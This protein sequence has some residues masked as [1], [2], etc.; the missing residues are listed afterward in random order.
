MKN[1]LQF[2]HCNRLFS[3]A[4][5]A[6]A[7]I[8]RRIDLDKQHAL[9]A[10]PIILKYGDAENP[11][12]LIGIGSVGDGESYGVSKNKIFYIDAAELAESIEELTVVADS[13]DTVN[14][15]S[16][17]IEGKNHLS[18]DVKVPATRIIG[19]VVKN[20]SIMATEDGIFSLVDISYDEQTNSIV[21]NVNE[22]TK[23]INLPSHLVRGE[24]K[25][26]GEDAEKLVLYMS[27]GSAIKIDMVDLIEE[28]KVDE[29]PNSPIVLTKEHV[30]ATTSTHDVQWQDI[31]SADVRIA[32]ADAVA[33]NILQKDSTNRYLY[34]KGTASNIS[35]W[36][37]QEKM[38]LQDA[39]NEMI[40]DVSGVQGNIIT[41]LSDGIFANV[42]L[43]FDPARNVLTFAKSGNDPKE[44]RL[45]GVNFIKRGYY[46]AQNEN[47]VI[48]YIDNNGEQQEI[49]IPASGLITEWGVDNSTSTV[50]LTKTPHQVSG[51][52]VLTANVKIGGG[53]NTNNIL[54]V[55]TDGH[56]LYVDGVANNIK[57]EHDSNTTVKD[58][59]DSL[60]GRIDDE[61]ARATS[62]ETR[63]ENAIGAVVNDV[64]DVAEKLYGLSGTV[65]T[66]AEEVAGLNFSVDNTDTVSMTKENGVVTSEVNID[67]R[68]PNI[69]VASQDGIRADIDFSYDENTNT[70]TVTKTNS[71]E[72]QEIKLN[73]TSTIESITYNKLTETLDFTYYKY[74]DGVK[75][76]VTD[77]IDLSDLIEEWD[78]DNT[79]KNVTLVKVR[80][81]EHP[82]VQDKLSANV[83]ISAAENN[84][85]EEVYESDVKKLFVK[86]LEPTVNEVS[87]AVSAMEGDIQTINSEIEALSGAVSGCSLV[88]HDTESVKFERNGNDVN[89][90][91]LLRDDEN[92]IIS[93]SNSGLFAKVSLTYEASENKLFFQTTNMTEPVAI[94]L[95]GVET[96]TNVSYDGDDPQNKVIK[97]TFGLQ[98]GSE[99]T[100]EIPVND[101]AKP[102]DV[103]P[104][105]HLGGIILTKEPNEDGV[106]ILSAEVVISNQSYN[107]LENDNGTLIVNGSGITKNANDIASLSAVV[108]AISAASSGS[109]A[110]LQLEVDNIER[111]VG[112]TSDGTYV[113]K[114]TSERLSGTTTMKEADEVLDSSLTAIEN[115]I[116][117]TGKTPTTTTFEKDGA[118]VSNV[119]LSGGR[120]GETQEDM[121]INQNSSELVGENALRIVD[122]GPS[123]NPDNNSNGLFLSN[124]W[125]CGTF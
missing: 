5:E 112:L 125:D 13:T 35:V 42:D 40:T 21:L 19:G 120:A 110:A 83:N 85:I 100:I 46:D 92:N 74:V 103:Q 95:A 90:E 26:K 76:L 88:F 122:Y 93:A 108:E 50:E 15:T 17:L 16:E 37:H 71:S 28:W 23:V 91:V 31:L 44:I 14:M 10:E 81:L 123:F 38:S 29:N 58:V 20:N 34:V 41:E 6:K 66:L 101:I 118:M 32:P 78:V 70:I 104:S 25:N 3:T 87:D 114:A 8:E 97:I 59:L 2:L 109:T 69:I 107:I 105:N 11:N 115:V 36:R 7:F 96:V 63:L 55:N 27:D 80:D 72:S 64:N 57:Y 39:I 22:D 56:S 82:E 61:T 99:K 1:R 98:D 43:T 47:I 117:A 4:E 67:E 75:T 77:S 45:N 102:W 106:D 113:P 124:I 53:P 121:T 68:N 111:N 84:A 54:E 9:Y 94:Q 51:T 119:R 48:V 49:V 65:D 52:D 18:A 60:Y 73:N 30:S 79:S 89:A 24:Y 86:D 33:D 116:N 62:A 12:I